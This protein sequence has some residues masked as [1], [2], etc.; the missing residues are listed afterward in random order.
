[1]TFLPHKYRKL[2]VIGANFQRP[3]STMYIS[4]NSRSGTGRDGKRKRWKEKNKVKRA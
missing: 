3:E 2:S 4:M 1:M